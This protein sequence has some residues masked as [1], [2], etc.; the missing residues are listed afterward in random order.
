MGSRL[1][2]C[3]P[4]WWEGQAHRGS[5]CYRATGPRVCLGTQPL[6][7]SWCS[8]IPAV[9][10]DL[11]G[12]P[13]PAL[14]PRPAPCFTASLGENVDFLKIF[15]RTSPAS[16]LSNG[17][18]SSPGIPRMGLGNKDLC[19]MCTLCVIFGKR[20]PQQVFTTSENRPRGRGT[21]NLGHLSFTGSCSGKSEA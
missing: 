5:W 15:S 16:Q 13:H 6:A 3:I 1:Q 17:F 20:N 7:E 10:T 11:C 8:M 4:G 2:V 21:P 12:A 19:F 14:S 18:F 9:Q